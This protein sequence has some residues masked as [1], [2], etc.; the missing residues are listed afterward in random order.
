[1]ATLHALE[2]RCQ[3]LDDDQLS[4]RSTNAWHH[5]HRNGVIRNL[6]ISAVHGINR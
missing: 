2:R 4:E 1:V 5:Y 6:V 3:G